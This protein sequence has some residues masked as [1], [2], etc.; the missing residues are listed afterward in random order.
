M[1]GGTVGVS[2]MPLRDLFG[3]GTA[4]GIND[5][6][7]LRRYAGSRDEAAFA[8]LVARHGP[9]VAATCRAVL[10]DHHD[11]EDAFQAAFLVLARKA[12][13]V[14][15]GEALGGWLHRV[16]YRAAV[17]RRIEVERRRRTEAEVPAMEIPD[18]SATIPDV[19]AC[20]ILHQELDRLP[21]ALRLPVVLC[22]LEGLTYEQAAARLRC[23]APA[24]YHRLAKGR[25][26]LRNHLI[27]RGLTAAAAG[28][29][30]E[31]ARASA[32]AAVPASW[33]SAV[34]AAAA[35]GAASP[36]AAALA[37]SL[38]GSLFLSRIRMMVVAGLAA[39]SVISAGVVVAGKERPPGPVEAPPPPPRAAGHTAAPEG[40]R[41]T[42]FIVEAR[43]LATDAPMPEAR[44]ELKAEDGSGSN[45]DFTTEAAAPG[46]TRYALSGDARYLRLN[47]RR[48]GFVPLSLSWIRD[49]ASPAPPDRFL[50]QM[51]K[52]TTVSGRVIDQDD[53]PVAGAAVIINVSKNYPRSRQ[54][55]DTRWEEI[56]TGTDGRWSFSGVPAEAGSI[57]LGTYHHGYLTESNFFN[58]TED[59][60]PLSALR[61]GS[62]ILRLHRGTPVEV[63]V[64]S[65]SGQ[66]VPN[67]EVFYGLGRGYGNAI[68]PA[69]TDSRGRLML[70]IKPGTTSSLIARAPRLGPVLESIRVG[71][72]PLRVDLTLPP[73]RVLTGTVLDTAR[74][75]IAAASVQVSW[76]GP[77][78]RPGEDRGSQ[79]I[80][81]SLITDAD[82][83]FT[84]KEAPAGGIR[85]SAG[86]RGFAA[87]PGRV[88]EA[89]TEHEHEI[90]LT[91]PTLVTGTVVDAETGRPI[92]RF[93]V[94]CGSVSNPDVPLIWQRGDDID[95]DAKKSP[96]AFEYAFASPSHRQVLRVSAEGYLPEE[97][98]RFSIEGTPHT[99]TFRLHRGEPIRGAVTRPDGSPATEGLVYLVPPEEEDTIEYLR[100]DNGA[101][102]DRARTAEETARIGPDGRFTLP[103]Q[104]GNFALVA[105][106]DAG[107]AI[108]PRREIQG[109][110]TL[111]LRPWARVSGTVT[112][113][114]KPAANLVMQSQDLDEPVPIP[115][116]PRIETR[117]YIRTDAEGRFDFPRVLPGRLRLGRWAPN[118][119]ER[120][121]WFTAM[122]T[123]D[124]EA[125][126]TYDLAIGRSGRKLAGRLEIPGGGR[127]AWMIRKAE[128]VAKDHDANKDP[129][130]RGVEVLPDGRIRAQDLPPGDYRLRIA[131]HEPPPGDACG[132]GRLI[133]SYDHG[134][135]IARDADDHPLDLGTLRPVEV[136]G[137]ALAVGDPAPDFAFRT[138]DGKEAKRSDLRGKV[139]LLDFWAT[140]CAPCVAEMPNLAAIQ[141]AY[142]PDPRFVLLS[143]SLD[144][145]P[146]Q[147]AYMAKVEKW[148]WRQAHVGPESPAVAAYG[149]TSIPATFLI[150]PD[151]KVLATGL[152]GEALR[153]AVSA[154]VGPPSAPGPPR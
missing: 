109:E 110:P 58:E 37:H 96:G 23:T 120:R 121:I 74:R 87:D 40:G 139:V 32:T 136:A 56:R 91:P 9:M 69:K 79:A 35:G 92:P 152:R 134:F 83:R 154:A 47:A 75:P 31:S 112:L 39:C 117:Y 98:G 42:H 73:P 21:D 90:V 76:S 25:T 113:D 59:F 150:A 36:A 5:A 128:I 141:R 77:A 8:A 143:V 26:R 144:D 71:D 115:G 95:R 1:A 149:A 7:L 48:P 12:G 66:P 148:S 131:L 20:S 19:E 28:V 145:R 57:R 65:T 43:D 53:R 55:I 100:I 85:V 33:T 78:T 86:A 129:V 63:T 132:W 82:G 44:I 67:A 93:T 4:I 17:E 6:E 24:L 125:G 137:R 102:R 119:L 54:W 60:R 34:L 68:P 11:A 114:G 103:P 126:K 51:E 72:R 107:S 52:A 138:L 108:V 104:R 70:G 18:R 81:A 89:G 3:G 116:E 49:A 45:L 147:P 146:A 99:F 97:T 50:F 10:R 127:G 135:T 133:A 105:L 151:G 142:G 41:P 124:V 130:L 15:A 101:I 122:T 153:E 88:V 140:W 16:A 118:G 22:D 27:R 13:S 111:R 80:A 14:R 64:R 106:C 30:M 46:V 61:D 2:P 84:W 29:A 94:S 123:I 38:I 62:A